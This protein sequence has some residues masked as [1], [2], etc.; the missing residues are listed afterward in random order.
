MH[1]VCLL[2]QKGGAGKSTVVES[3][4]VCAGQHGQ[5]ALIIE[6]D[7]QGTLKDW[8]NRREAEQP[9]VIQTLPQ[10]IGDELRDAGYRG[11]DWV[12]IDTPGHHNPAAV[13]AAA[14]ADLILI[15]CK[16]LSMKDVDAILPTIAEAERAHKPAYVIMNQVPPNAPKLV[17]RRQVSIQ[18]DY[19]IKVLSLC[20]SRRADFEYCD[21]RGLS[22]A[23]YNPQGAAAAEIEKLYVLVQAILRVTKPEENLETTP[24]SQTIDSTQPETDETIQHKATETLQPG[25]NEAFQS[26]IP[27]GIVARED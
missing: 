5:N 10:S 16:I 15:P 1:V 3:L 6:L 11:V 8:S 17:R 24:R 23:E 14:Y 22:A 26:R 18:E 19:K 27:E 25:T 20:L 13:A 7:P 2:S 21:A 12:F 9:R 4:A